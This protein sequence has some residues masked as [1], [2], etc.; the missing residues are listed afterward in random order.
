MKITP[1]L[2]AVILNALITFVPKIFGHLGVLKAI[3]AAAAEADDPNGTIR[4]MLRPLIEERL[5][6]AQREAGSN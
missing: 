6:L 3:D 5:A 2:L 1:E 4:A